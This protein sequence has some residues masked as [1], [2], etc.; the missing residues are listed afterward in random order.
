MAACSICIDHAIRCLAGV[1]PGFISEEDSTAERRSGSH[2]VL[3]SGLTSS[4]ISISLIYLLASRTS[5]LSQDPMLWFTMMLIPTGPPALKLTALADMNGSSE[6]EKMS[7][8]KFLSVSF[9][10]I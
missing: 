3:N 8:A 6:D 5:W 1:S 2:D 9:G 10:V 7:I 4:S